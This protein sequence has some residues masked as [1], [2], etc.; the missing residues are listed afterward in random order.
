MS[1]PVKRGIAGAILV[2]F[3]VLVIGFGLFGLTVA[4]WAS[5]W[6]SLA[7]FTAVALFMWAL[8]VTGEPES[9]EA[10]PKDSSSQH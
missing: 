9:L 3:W 2:V 10:E 6:V 1:G 7:L 4:I 8:R 5:P